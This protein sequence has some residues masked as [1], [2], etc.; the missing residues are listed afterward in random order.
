MLVSLSLHLKDSE[1]GF[2]LE[3]VPSFCWYSVFSADY[4][5]AQI[6]RDAYFLP[7]RTVVV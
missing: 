5:K 2:R 7:N 3:S 1:F 4:G 6:P